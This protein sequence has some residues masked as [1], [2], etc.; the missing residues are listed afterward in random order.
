MNSSIE[1]L[2]LVYELAGSCEMHDLIV[3]E[4]EY[5]YMVFGSWMIIIGKSKHRT[6][7]SWDGKESYLDISMSDF[8]NSNSMPD[9]KPVFPNVGGTK[10][11]EAEVFAFVMEVLEKQY[12]MK[13]L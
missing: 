3:Y 7:F 11:T 12:E 1:H 8:Q 10:K 13:K 6:K 5:S 9:W 2:K 4:H